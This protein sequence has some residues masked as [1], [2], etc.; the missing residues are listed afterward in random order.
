MPGK[1][2]KPGICLQLEHDL[3]NME[4]GLLFNKNLEPKIIFAKVVLFSKS[5]YKMM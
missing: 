3:E 4:N 5:S 2:G 1:P